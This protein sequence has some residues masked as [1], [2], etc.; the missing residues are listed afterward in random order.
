VAKLL[1]PN[2]QSG[3]LQPE[4]APAIHAKDLLAVPDRNA[5]QIIRA[6]K[7]ACFFIKAGL[8]TNRR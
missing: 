1:W 2:Q 8:E 4:A 6:I 5:W 3:P 7:K